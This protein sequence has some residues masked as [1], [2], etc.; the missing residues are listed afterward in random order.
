MRSAG[1]KKRRPHR[2]WRLRHLRRSRRLRHLRRRLPHIPKAGQIC[3]AAAGFT[4]RRP[5]LIGH[6]ARLRRR[7]SSRHQ[8]SRRHANQR[9]GR[10][11]DR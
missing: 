4:R 3:C 5:S 2:S 11:A 10:A 6:V 1:A 9:P 7:L 8:S